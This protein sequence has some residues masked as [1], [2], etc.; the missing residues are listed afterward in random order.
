MQFSLPGAVLGKY[1]GKEDMIHGDGNTPEHPVHDSHSYDW[2]FQFPRAKRTTLSKLQTVTLLDDVS[3]LRYR[4]RLLLWV[5]PD[6]LK[7]AFEDAE[8]ALEVGVAIQ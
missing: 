6:S 4:K 8:I 3:I 1:F 2:I 7:D 5:M